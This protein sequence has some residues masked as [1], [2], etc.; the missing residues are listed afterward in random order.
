MLFHYCQCFLQE[1]ISAEWWDQ[2]FA[3]SVKFSG[4]P[5][6][7]TPAVSS[8]PISEEAGD[9]F[10]VIATDGLWYAAQPCV[11]QHKLGKKEEKRSVT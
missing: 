2:E 8:I 9:E 6:I 11:L 3:D 5:V 4:D 1:G 7:A 10:L